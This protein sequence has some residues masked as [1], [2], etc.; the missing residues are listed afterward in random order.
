[1]SAPMTATV[2]SEVRSILASATAPM[3]AHEI[4]ERCE[5]ADRVEQVCSTLGHL[6]K[7]GEAQP[8][9]PVIG[10]GKM[11][12]K[13]WVPAGYPPATAPALDDTEA[14]R[15]MAALEDRP[16]KTDPLPAILDPE[17]EAH[18]TPIPRLD[19]DWPDALEAPPPRRSRPRAPAA[20]IPPPDDDPDDVEFRSVSARR[21]RGFFLADLVRTAPDPEPRI[22]GADA[23]AEFLDA[24]AER[25]EAGRVIP[26]HPEIAATLREICHLMARHG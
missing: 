4:F 23:Y 8:A 19:T 12:R 21:A 3:T 13:T 11:P 25:L 10:T 1:M 6:R 17:P 22:L 24:C 9:E 20:P 18:E 2:T 14:A 26:A 7:L 16:T 15:L 5:L